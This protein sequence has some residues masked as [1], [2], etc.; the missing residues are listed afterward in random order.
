MK[1]NRQI[2]YGRSEVKA[3]YFLPEFISFIASLAYKL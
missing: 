2:P 3:A 1:W